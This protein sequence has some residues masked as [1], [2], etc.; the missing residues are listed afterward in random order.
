MVLMAWAC[1]LGLV[2]IGV[3]PAL[4]SNALLFSVCLFDGCDSIVTEGDWGDNTLK[5]EL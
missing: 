2:A 1:S 5:S 4:F 3:T